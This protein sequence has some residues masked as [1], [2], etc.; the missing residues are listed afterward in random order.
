AI[1]LN[2]STIKDALGNDAT[3]SFTSPNTGN[4]LVDTIAPTAA[5]TYSPASAAKSGSTLTITATFNKPMA[6]SPVPAI[7]I[8][9]VTGGTELA[10]TPITRVDSTHYTYIYTVQ[11]GSG[12]ATVTMGAG[13]DL[14]GNVVSPTPSSG[15]TFT[16]DN[17]APTASITYAPTGPVKAGTTLTLTATFTDVM[18]SAPAPQFSV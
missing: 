6:D 13:T 11:G 8:S 2:G 14:A 18:A 9:A 5:L 7:A 12:T 10:A 3:L 15:D 4:V 17:T 16:V 1:S